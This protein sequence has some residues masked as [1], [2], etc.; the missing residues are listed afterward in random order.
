VEID[1]M[2]VSTVQVAH[3]REGGAPGIFMQG[4]TESSL[5]AMQNS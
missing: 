2:P 1:L 3:A 4:Y 5:V